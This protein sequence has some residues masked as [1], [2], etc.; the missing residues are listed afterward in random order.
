MREHLESLG[1][2]AEETPS[3]EEL[4]KR[5]RSLCKEH[6]PDLGGEHEVFLSVMHAYNMLTDPVYAHQNNEK[7]NTRK[8]DYDVIMQYAVSFME[9]FAGKEESFI[10]Y[11]PLRIDAN[12]EP[13]ISETKIECIR[14][15]LFPGNAFS[16]EPLIFEGRGNYG[17]DNVRGK[18]IIQ[19]FV[20]PHPRFQVR[21]TLLGGYDILSVEAI[22]LHVLLKGGKIKID[23]MNGHVIRKIKPGTNANEHIRLAGLGIEGGSQ[24][25]KLDL[26]LP[27]EKDLKSAEYRGLEIDWGEDTE[28]DDLLIKELASQLKEVRRGTSRATKKTSR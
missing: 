20:V 26:V 13:V 12:G 19:M 27:G 23:T 9:A 4:K 10:S 25:V 28:L 7:K 21:R 11:I 6:H 3:P 2:S 17:P 18:L 24:Y 16:G 14:F 1:F 22:P 8:E 5:W 15:R